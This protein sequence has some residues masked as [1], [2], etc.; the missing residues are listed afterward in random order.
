MFLV[1]VDLD[2]FLFCAFLC[3]F[4]FE[5]RLGFRDCFDEEERF[6][7]FLFGFI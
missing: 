7:C 4:D 1:T 3:S 6:L 5:V 2:P